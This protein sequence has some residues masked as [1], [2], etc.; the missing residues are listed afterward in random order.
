MAE[1]IFSWDE[2]IKL[3]VENEDLRN[4]IKI[5]TK[6]EDKAKKYALQFDA[7]NA[8]LRVALSDIAVSKVLASVLAELG[9]D[10]PTPMGYW[11]S[12]VEIAMKALD[13]NLP[14]DKK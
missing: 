9:E 11:K 2:F 4:A 10:E 6:G 3:K 8:A 5:S 12:S 13:L 14:E 1:L 7:E